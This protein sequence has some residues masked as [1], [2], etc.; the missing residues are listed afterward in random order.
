MKDKTAVPVL[1]SN[2]KDKDIEIRKAAI[3]AMGDFGNKT[4][5]V[6]LTEYLNDKDPALRSAAQN[7]LNKL[8]E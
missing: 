2:L 4:Y 8:K 7:A 1:I 5:T 6:L 3:N